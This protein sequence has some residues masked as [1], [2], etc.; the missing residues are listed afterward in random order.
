MDAQDE[1]DEDRLSGL[2]GGAG[3]GMLR[4]TLLFG[5]AAVA[6]ALILAPV[7]EERAR[8]MVAQSSPGLDW[9]TTGSVARDQSTSYV[10]RRSVLQRSPDAVCMIRP[11][12][13]SSG[14]C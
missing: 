1:K 5:S 11:D 12:G 13:T 8:G 2:L 3:A 7:A 4:V 10:L 6:L 9:T 14:D